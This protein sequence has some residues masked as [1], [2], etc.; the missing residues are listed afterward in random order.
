MRRAESFSTRRPT[1]PAN[2]AASVAGSRCDLYCPEVG[3]FAGAAGDSGCAAPAPCGTRTAW[4]SAANASLAFCCLPSVPL[5]W[6]VRSAFAAVTAF[7][8]LLGFARGFLVMS[9]LASATR[10]FARRSRPPPPLSA[11]RYACAPGTA[12]RR[13][14]TACEV[15]CFAVA[16]VAYSP[17]NDSSCDDRR[18]AVAAGVRLQHRPRRQRALEAL[19]HLLQGRLEP[20]GRDRPKWR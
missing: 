8:R 11:F 17:S 20:L 18:L 16:T 6:R 12:A 13:V 1:S 14:T 19:Q 9:K 4:T 15:A 10:S 7:F 3:G 5:V 2:A